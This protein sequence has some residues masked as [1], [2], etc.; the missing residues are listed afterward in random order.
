MSRDDGLQNVGPVSVSQPLIEPQQP[1]APL[2]H[3]LP[4]SHIP[5]GAPQ[6]R[7]GLASNRELSSLQRQAQDYAVAN[8]LVDYRSASL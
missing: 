4:Q 1:N 5:M 2:T 3:A 6:H 7:P 8:M